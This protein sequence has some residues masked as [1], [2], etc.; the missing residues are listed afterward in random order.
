MRS[1]ALKTS[2]A[3]LW[4]FCRRMNTPKNGTSLQFAAGVL[5]QF[6]LDVK[7]AGC[8]AAKMNHNGWPMC[9]SSGQGTLRRK[10]KV[11]WRADDA[12]AGNR[13]HLDI[14]DKQWKDHLLT[15]DH[16]KEGDRLLQKALTAQKDPLVEFKKKRSRC[17][18]T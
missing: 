7:A 13:H 10:R 1:A 4:H 14:V 9:W 12:L 8:D 3:N 15:L 11:V 5:N 2:H 16:L 6:G 17:S 18:R